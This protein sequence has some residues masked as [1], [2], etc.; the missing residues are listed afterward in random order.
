ME[1]NRESTWMRS[2]TMISG[3]VAALM[4]SA[5]ALEPSSE[6]NEGND[7]GD[8]SAA[9]MTSQALS[10]GACTAVALTSPTNGF[11]GVAGVPIA[12]SAT[13]SCPMGSTPEFQF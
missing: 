13:A 5:C 10:P 4:M 8:D 2:A 9:A 3:A 1:H 12:L 7:E 6:G 11:T